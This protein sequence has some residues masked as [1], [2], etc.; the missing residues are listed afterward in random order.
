MRGRQKP[1]QTGNKQILFNGIDPFNAEFAAIWYDWQC[2]GIFMHVNVL[3]VYGNDWIEI[4]LNCVYNDYT[5]LSREDCAKNT[6]WGA[7]CL[8]DMLG[9]LFSKEGKKATQF[10]RRFNSLGIFFNLYI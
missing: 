9:I 4:G 2:S 6:A 10:D 5:V 1:N 7:E 3:V 8:F